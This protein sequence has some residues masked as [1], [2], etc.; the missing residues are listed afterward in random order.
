MVRTGESAGG[1][2]WSGEKNEE[3]NEL[4][5]LKCHQTNQQTVEMITGD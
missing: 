1:Q 4:F 3:G 2:R 5:D